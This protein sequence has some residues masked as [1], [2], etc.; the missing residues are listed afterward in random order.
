MHALSKTEF[1]V[2]GAK[3]SWII[4]IRMFIGIYATLNYLAVA[5]RICKARRNAQ[6]C[7]TKFETAQIFCKIVW[8]FLELFLTNTL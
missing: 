2:D 4:E 3:E 8:G 6:V 5:I 1:Y 7:Q